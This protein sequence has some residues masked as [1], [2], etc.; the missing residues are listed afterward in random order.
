MLFTVSPWLHLQFVREHEQALRA[1]QRIQIMMTQIQPHFLFN[2]LSTIRALC[3]KDP[4]KA[5]FLSGACQA[6]A[7]TGTDR[8]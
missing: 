8:R 6:T 4:P 2:T 5:I 7:K 3:A 1:E